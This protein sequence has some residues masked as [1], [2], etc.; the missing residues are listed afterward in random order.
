MKIL[1]SPHDA[2]ETLP[3]HRVVTLGTFDGVHRGH[4][5][6][7]TQL[8]RAGRA[9]GLDEVCA[10]TFGPHP[11]AVLTP[12]DVPALLN[13]RADREK[14][15]AA[16]GV[17]LLVVLDFTPEL[18][19]LEYDVFVREILLRR[20]GLQHFVL[21]HD[22]HFGRG[23]GGNVHTVT[24]LGD[25]EGF[26]V[27]QVPSVHVDG[28]PVSSTRIRRALAEGELERAVELLGHPH[29]LSGPV[30]RGR[31]LGRGLGFPT[32]N[33]ELPGRRILPALGVYAGW[34]RWEG[35]GWH[36]AVLNVGR[37]PTVAEGDRPRVEVH[38]PGM[39]VDLY[40]KHLEVALARRLRPEQK[41]D[42]LE[43]LKAAIAQDVQRS[44]SALH[45]LPWTAR[46][47]RLDDLTASA[48]A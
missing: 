6:V 41:F 31:Q 33:L 40:E 10:V 36:R 19:A 32:A 28:E 25:E 39:D 22:V 20:L 34:A 11:R 18:A 12:K 24:E 35:S 1:R 48:D 23:R 3:G 43:A 8:R 47:E 13:S 5:E 38:L 2:L 42:G 17:Q 26:L 27:S 29:L 37:G 15:L 30:V 9:D 46:P 16:A 44:E 14:M 21:G 4:Q 7:L 45:D